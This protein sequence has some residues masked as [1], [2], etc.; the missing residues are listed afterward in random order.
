MQIFNYKF[1]SLFL[2]SFALLDGNAQSRG[3]LVINFGNNPEIASGQCNPLVS[4]EFRTIRENPNISIK[5]MID[6]QSVIT[7]PIFKIS[8]NLFK[9]KYKALN[10]TPLDSSCSEVDL[11]IES[12]RCTDPKTFMLTE[13]R[14]EV[15]VNGAGYFRSVQNNET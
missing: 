7:Q 6:G 12:V 5:Y 9:S 3:V 10:I 13:C 4:Y 11:I 15:E 8:E 2:L 1:V 14:I